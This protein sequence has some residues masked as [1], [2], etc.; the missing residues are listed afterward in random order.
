MFKFKKIV[1]LKGF[2]VV[3]LEDLKLL[4]APAMCFNSKA[5]QKH[6]YFC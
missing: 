4:S 1:T 2:S 5:S 6:Q 3:V